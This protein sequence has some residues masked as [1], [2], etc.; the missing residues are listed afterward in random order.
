MKKIAALFLVSFLALNSTTHGA[1][2]F[3]SAKEALTSFYNQEAQ[4]AFNNNKAFFKEHRELEIELKK[5]ALTQLALS[6]K[7]NTTNPDIKAFIDLNHKKLERMSLN[8]T[9]EEFDILEGIQ[10][11]QKELTTLESHNPLI[12]KRLSNALSNF[13]KKQFY[14]LAFSPEKLGVLAKGMKL[15]ITVNKEALRKALPYAS[16]FS[17]KTSLYSSLMQTTLVGL[18]ASTAVHTLKGIDRIV[19]LVLKKILPPIQ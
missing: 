11:V 2:T 4:K 18:L 16:L 10:E 12:Y 6:E 7:D 1:V 17:E 9:R 14:T 19:H 15:E 8:I 3:S 5:S 13:Q